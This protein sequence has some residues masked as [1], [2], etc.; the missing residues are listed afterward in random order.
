METAPELTSPRSPLPYQSST[1]NRV[2]QKKGTR[3]KMII[4]LGGGRGQDR[5]KHKFLST[6]IKQAGE[7]AGEAYNAQPR[8]GSHKKLV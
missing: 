8:Q 6:R 7:P 5:A 4:Y 3:N 2:R 1:T